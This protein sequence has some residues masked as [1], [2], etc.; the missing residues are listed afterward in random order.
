MKTVIDSPLG[1]E[2]Q[3]QDMMAAFA[4]GGCTDRELVAALMVICKDHADAA[5]QALALVDRAHRT[6]VVSDALFREIKS[7]LNEI[8][9]SATGAFK[10]TPAPTRRSRH[11]SARQVTR[12]LE[13][14]PANDPEFKSSASSSHDRYVIVEPLDGGAAT[15]TY[16]ALDRQR[17][18]LPDAERYVVLRCLN[19][20]YQRN[21]HAVAAL[22]NEFAQLRAIAHRAIPKAYE[23][24]QALGGAALALQWQAGERLST[25]LERLGPRPL[26]TDI[27]A[28]LVCEVGLALAHAHKHGVVHGHIHPANI[29]LTERGQVSVRDFARADELILQTDLT[30]E[31]AVA[32]FADDFKDY[33]SPQRLGHTA[34]GASDDLY[35]LG[36]LAQ[37]LLF[38]D[39]DA[40]SVHHHWL[41]ARQRRM[42][43]RDALR[44]DP[45]E[46]GH[47]V[48]AWLWRFG[49][50]D[51]KRALP[52]PRAIEQATRRRWR[53]S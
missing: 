36:R 30:G 38:G 43:M 31:F 5:W 25:L 8:V 41:I 40:T 18:Q 23:L 24:T 12:R 37:R 21:A 44:T 17:N 11:S 26:P 20:P 4:R 46:R 32:K 15:T 27:A 51:A 14:A 52:P 10:A 34:V 50:D 19:Q 47:D 29:V 42:A 53:W 45:H 49:I 35:S 7:G 3:V 1:S 16:K 22:Q 6:Q 13:R 39:T 2:Q 9:F 33:Y 28:T 48:A